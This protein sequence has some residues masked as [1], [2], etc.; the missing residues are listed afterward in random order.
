M[1]KRGKDNALVSYLHSIA[2]ELTHYFQWLNGIELTPIGTERQAVRYAGL[3]L[4]KY[5]ETREHP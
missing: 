5:A 2:H 4:D 1:K 3:I